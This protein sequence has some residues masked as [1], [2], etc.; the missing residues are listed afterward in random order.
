MKKKK[1]EPGNIL[2]LLIRENLKIYARILEFPL[3][4]YYKEYD[5]ENKILKE[6]IF[7]AM[8]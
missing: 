5:K 2:E 1:Q 8:K 4:A 7:E 3:V 6:C